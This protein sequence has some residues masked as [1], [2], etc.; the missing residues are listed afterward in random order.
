MTFQQA[1][2]LSHAPW[3]IWPWLRLPA[4][5]TAAL[6]RAYGGEKR[7]PRAVLIACGRSRPYE[8]ERKQL[9]IR[10]GEWVFW[11]EV[12]LHGPDPC[13][14]AI[15][16]RTLFPLRAISRG[17]RPLTKHGNRPIGNTL[18]RH[19][20]LRRSPIRIR[21]L[22]AAGSGREWQR[23]S[24]LVQGRTRIFIQERFLADLP[25]WRGRGHP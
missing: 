1:A 7:F 25:S 19:R 13:R 6:R 24:I 11:R 9:G 14:P 4:S 20:R 12:F 16:G 8:N 2:S 3:A 15:Q 21:T 23:S 18:F 17:L 5:L 10:R 22:P